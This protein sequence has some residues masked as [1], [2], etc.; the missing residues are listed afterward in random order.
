MLQG[1]RVALLSLCLLPLWA[2]ADE[3]IEDFA[4][5]LQVQADASLLV[6]ER[7]TVRA[8]GEQIKR[9]IYR[10]LPVRYAMALGLNKSGP[11]SLL[12]VTRDGQPEQVTTER[13]GAWL[14]YYIGSASHRL[15][16]GRYQYEL[17]YRVE[18][19]L[20]HHEGR[21]E[22]Y[23]NVTGN[24]WLFPILQA[25]VEVKLP[26]GARIGELAA[27]TG[28]HGEQGKAFEVLERGDDHLRL[29]TTQALPAYHGLTLALDWPAGLVARPG[30][31]QRLGYLLLDNLGLCL[32]AL[33]LVGLLLF[34]LRAWERFG[35]D[36]QKGLI[37]PLFE[38][39]QGMSAV[40][41]GYLWHRGFKS[42]YQEARAFSVWLTDMAIRKHL[43]IE[44]DASGRG[45]SL[46]RGT[47][48]LEDGNAVDRDLCSRLFPADK[49]GVALKIGGGYEPRLAKA[50][51]G[52]RSRLQKQG[53]R[54]FSQNRGIW[55]CGLV[56]A[57]VA[58]LV[59]VFAGAQGEDEWGVGLGGVIF[60]LGFCVPSLFVLRMA[61]QQP[62]RGR[63]IGLSL[64]ALLFVWP[65]P[66]GL[67]MLS[68]AASVPALLLLCVYV[69][70]V[71]LFY[72]LLPA[73]SVKG[74]RLL[75]GLEGYRE[76]LQLAESDALALAGDAP[77]MSIALYERHLPYAMALGVED[78]WSARFSAALAGGLIDPTQ[79]DYRPDWYH[80]RSDFSTPLAM[81]SALAA[82]LSSATALASSPPSSSSSGG[83]GGGGSSGGGSSGGGGG[84]GGGGG[85]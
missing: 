1:V 52:L 61:W 27:Y 3:V 65:V 21:D 56:W 49:D 82:G 76:Y 85:W 79:R 36:P 55:A 35:R 54:W 13:N 34:Y 25:S 14:R 69:L 43:H 39:P 10:D 84:G 8:E 9:G 31:W 50:M 6:T 42:P 83:G 33:M 68:D 24:Q 4:V 67:W 41:A 40:Q 45:F 7:I 37:I 23:W 2:A 26:P 62:T 19:Q 12:G 71:V 48:E 5:T 15:Q 59:L 60:T 63:R 38:A 30:V 64:A 58:C 77:A 73:P 44:D 47:G 18:R 11:I 80:S 22:L 78:K 74:R 51:T 75:D 29:A 53:K 81:S 66:V 57:V 16:S 28:T 32:G 20:L 70:V 46:A 17:R 72:Y